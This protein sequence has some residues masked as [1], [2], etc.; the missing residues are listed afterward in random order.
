YK[1]IESRQ[2]ELRFAGYTDEEIAKILSQQ[3][4]L[5]LIRG[6]KAI[7]YTSVNKDELISL[8]GFKSLETVRQAIGIAKKDLPGIKADIIYPLAVH[9]NSTYERII[10]GKQIVNPKID[11]IKS[12]YKNEFKVAVKMCNL[13]S[14]RLN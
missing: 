10:N 1:F 5:E 6:A 12:K 11:V 2:V 3:V 4:E 13:I 9:L 14:E 8:V 7:N